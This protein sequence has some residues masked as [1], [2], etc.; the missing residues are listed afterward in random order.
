MAGKF[1]FEDQDVSLVDVS[2][3]EKS[4]S[5]DT[6]SS[7]ISADIKEDSE[8]LGFTDRSPKK[9]SGTNSITKRKPGRKPP[10]EPRIPVMVSGPE[11]VIQRFKQYCEQNGNLPYWEGLKRLM[12]SSETI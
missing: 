6:Q 11:S 12:D 8:N 2:G 1:G 5:R 10:S 3:L 4:V 9:A 7:G